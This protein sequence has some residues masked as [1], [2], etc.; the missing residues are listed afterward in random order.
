MLRTAVIA[1][2]TLAAANASADV[3]STA[4]S[5]YDAVQQLEEV[6]ATYPK[7]PKKGLS[8]PEYAQCLPN[9]RERKLVKRA[10]AACELI[11][12]IDSTHRHCID[13][14]AYRGE[15]KLG[16]VDI[17][18]AII[19][20]PIDPMKLYSHGGAEGTPDPTI[21]FLARFGDRASAAKIADAWKATATKA[22]KFKPGSTQAYHWTE[23]RKVA[24]RG[25][26]ILGGKPE[27]QFLEGLMAK[28]TD[29][30]L[31]ELMDAAIDHL[32]P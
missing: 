8:F 28:E 18:A 23:W 17:A 31:I 16:S 13:L 2:I 26:A 4:Q 24:I 29:K 7:T 32:D 5:S 11:V 10:I 27:K 21:L 15:R 20:R 12:Q 9:I 14:A 1:T 19:A 22:A 6:A 25:M 30:D 3:C